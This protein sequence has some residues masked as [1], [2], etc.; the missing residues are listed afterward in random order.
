V[1]DFS[2]IQ[3]PFEA[4]TDANAG[5]DAGPLAIDFLASYSENDNLAVMSVFYPSYQ[6]M[7]APL[8]PI[9]YL[10]TSMSEE[11]CPT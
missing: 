10:E 9:Q 6:H 11:D 5:A 7:A 1:S 3:T 8:S 2:C 4:I